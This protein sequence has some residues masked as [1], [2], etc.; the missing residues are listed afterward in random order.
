MIDSDFGNLELVARIGDRYSHFWHQREADTWHGPTPAWTEPGLDL[1]AE[2]EWRVPYSCSIVGIHA[3]LLHTGKVL[4][5]S[6]LAETDQGRGISCVLD[7]STGQETQLPNLDK[8]PF[9]GGHAFLPDG[10]LVVSGG[11]GGGLPSMH[12]FE[13]SG[14]SGGWHQLP[15]MK[16]ARWYPTCTTLPDGRILILSG[17]VEGG[18]QPSVP[19]NDTY[20]IYS[21]A[22]GLS[23]RVQVE[24]LNEISPVSIYPF[25]FVLPSGK[26]L[27]HGW[28]KTCF[29][30]LA[31]EQVGPERILTNR[32]EPRNYPVQGA[33]VLLP[34]LPDADPPYRARVML[35]GGGGVPPSTQNAA[36][37]T[38]EILDLGRTS[39]QWRSAAS[40]GRPRVMCD[41]VLLP[42]RTV[43][44]V[45]GSAAGWAHDANQPVYD[46]EI[47]NPSTGAWTRVCSR[48]VPRLYHAS[49]LLLPDGRVLTAGSDETYNIEPF[50]KH[51][52]RIEIFSPPYLFRGAR[53]EFAP[54]GAPD[55]IT[56]GSRF[57]VRTPHG[58]SIGSAALLRPGTATHSM[59]MD[60]RYVGLRIA[61]RSA[62]RLTL[63][64][65]P[66]G[67]VAPPG[68]YMLFLVNKDG[69]PSVASFVKLE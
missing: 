49:A 52:L 50:H 43:L 53:P 40:M 51:E 48:R 59:N 67:N 35:I 4:L 62:S 7:P 45:N 41:A 65:P 47:F 1:G 9:C 18:T 42:D 16:A 68:Y 25:V 8:D 11:S 17:T 30:D 34:L 27:I 36:T 33:A 21:A 10:R 32:S 58:R 39:P 56:Y 63:E 23:S 6:Y 19:L 37:D 22:S 64:A 55:G 15:D 66:N 28:N 61:S 13:P 3:A 46:T 5:F 31:A 14:D 20:Q 54:G 69:V 60:Q 44:V 38:C 2:G 57:I 26:I 29:L 12:I 24:Y